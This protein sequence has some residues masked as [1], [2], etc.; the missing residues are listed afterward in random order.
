MHDR[1]TSELGVHDVSMLADVEEE[2]LEDLELKKPEKRALWKGIKE[3]QV[4]SM[5]A[6]RFFLGGEG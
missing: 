6:C 5:H 3:V 4:G 2:D 1:L